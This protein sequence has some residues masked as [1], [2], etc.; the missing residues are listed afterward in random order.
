[1]S[2]GYDGLMQDYVFMRRDRVV[3]LPDDINMKVAAFSELIS[4][5]VHAILRFEGKSNANRES[6]GV[7]G[8]GNLGF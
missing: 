3:A 2:S 8:D 6:F 1:R 4:V 5:A 7:W